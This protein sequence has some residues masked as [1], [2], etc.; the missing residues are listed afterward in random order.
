[1]G[2]PHLNKSRGGVFSKGKQENG[3]RG[4][5]ATDVGHIART[6]KMLLS[7]YQKI[8]DAHFTTEEA[9]GE[10]EAFRG[11]PE[12]VEVQAKLS[13]PNIFPCHSL[14]G[15]AAHILPWCLPPA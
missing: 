9:D 14:A 5:E 3:R 12:G 7:H 2:Q 8:G 11:F 15:S 1:M 13:P 4:D 10:S 6:D